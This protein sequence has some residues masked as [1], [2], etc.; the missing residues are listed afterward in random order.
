MQIL[1]KISLVTIVIL[2]FLAGLNHFIHPTGYVNIIPH[3]LPYVAILNILAG[4]AEILFALL[5][6]RSKTRKVAAWGIIL[7]LIAFL[8]VHITMLA[9]APFKL[10]NLLVTPTIAWARLALQ[11]VLMLW[12][13][14]HRK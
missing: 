6:I 13:W 14:W 5:L 12:A 7:M 3:Y 11:P 2:Y 8:P 1:K 4:I 10:G 9:N